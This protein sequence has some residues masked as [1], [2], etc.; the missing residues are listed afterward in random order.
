MSV[1]F[2]CDGCGKRVASKSGYKPSAWFE[3]TTQVENEDGRDID[4]TYHACDRDC[5][6]RVAAKTDGKATVLPI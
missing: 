3:R 4:V 6:K 2:I 5:I 1:E